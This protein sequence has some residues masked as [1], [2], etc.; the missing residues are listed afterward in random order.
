MKKFK[1][2]GKAHRSPSSSS[3]S[4]IDPPPTLTNS[5]RLITSSTKYS[6]TRSFV[7]ASVH[8]TAR[9]DAANAKPND[10]ARLDARVG[11]NVAASHAERQPGGLI[12]TNGRDA[13]AG[14][15]PSPSPHNSKEMTDA[16]ARSANR[17][18]K[19]TLAEHK[20]ER[21]ASDQCKSIET[22]HNVKNKLNLRSDAPNPAGNCY[23]S[24]NCKIRSELKNQ[25]KLHLK[26]DPNLKLS[27]EKY[28]TLSSLIGGQSKCNCGSCE[29]APAAAAAA[30]V[31]SATAA[32]PAT[33]DRN[34]NGNATKSAEPRRTSGAT[35][36]PWI[37][38]SASRARD[39]ADNVSAS[40][41]GKKV[42]RSTLKSGA[43]AADMPGGHRKSANTDRNARRPATAKPT[44]NPS[45]SMED[46]A[47]HVAET[48]DNSDRF[49][50]RR[51]HDD[52]LKKP[53]RRLNSLSRSV[54]A[55]LDMDGERSATPSNDQFSPCSDASDSCASRKSAEK[56]ASSADG[57][58][59]TAPTTSDASDPNGTKASDGS[60]P[61][62]NTSSS[63][64]DINNKLTSHAFQTY[65]EIQENLEDKNILA[66]RLNVSNAG[67]I[68]RNVPDAVPATICED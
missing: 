68:Q 23:I 28:S 62:C 47:L 13:L 56:T 51:P 8:G 12:E 10:T 21:T 9:P 30:A 19:P 41:A 24:I 54:D 20:T 60:A 4:P 63:V 33:G 36:D 29:Q 3:S 48:G 44:P 17:T 65:D 55:H 45:Q 15:S 26:A 32:P 7:D 31:G 58:N 22:M 18:A 35:F 39:S 57:P 67:D 61:D 66:K 52:G 5:H 1:D 6:P 37:K 59:E 50:E 11:A 64:D 40:T 38:Q 2:N 16:K 46:V 53:L 42:V 14:K 34:Q 27:L 25:Y 49:G 43:S